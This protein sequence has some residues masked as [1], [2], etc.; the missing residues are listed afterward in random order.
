MPINRRSFMD[1]IL[2]AGALMG[3]LSGEALP[4]SQTKG[5]AGPPPG[6]H[7]SINFWSDFYAN[8][9]S[10]GRQAS[11]PKLPAPE[12]QVQFLNHG[13]KGLRY[14]SD[15]PKDE[16]LDHG[17]DV[18]VT[19]NMGQFRPSEADRAAFKQL[20]TSSLRLDCVQTRPMMNLFAP[21]AWASLASLFPDKQGKLPSLQ[22]LGFQA[23][24]SSAPEN[25]VV[26]PYGL[27]K[28]A[29]N[30]SM[31]HKESLVH[32]ILTEAQS[33]AGITAPFFAFPAISIPALKAVTAI[34]SALEQHTTFLLNSPL[35][36]TVATRQALDDESREPA[37]L[38]LVS[39]DY[40]LVPKAHQGEL[41]KSM[42][43][44]DLTQ[45]F[46]IDKDAPANQP[47]DVRA[48]SAIPGVTYV[49]MR[50]TV[51]PLAAGAASQAKPEAPAD[52]GGDAPAAAKSPAAP[53]KK[54]K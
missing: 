7:D 30:I 41:S 23:T 24:G 45:G 44:L 49:T 10:R 33:I 9:P 52:S 19:I 50:V 31:V 38:P 36:M 39:G 54:K 4:Q 43:R 16:L 1:E 17:G 46:L 27:G 51:A 29:V 8:A 14:T 18:S 26:L 40:V 34:Y 20:Q 28:M 3:L 12:R 35:T 5:T 47:P 48:S 21:L 2:A 53:A 13:A 11:T 6:T 42:D 32:K 25:K 22:T 37:Y 15:I